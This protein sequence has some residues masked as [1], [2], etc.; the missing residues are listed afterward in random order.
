MLE[1]DVASHLRKTQQRLNYMLREKVGE[2]KL[3]FRLLHILMRIERNPEA[4]QNEIA[5]ELKFTKGS[6]SGYVSRLMELGMLEKSASTKDQRCN[7]LV[8][9]IYGKSIL[10]DYE[11][12]VHL[13]YKDIFI[14]FSPEELASFDASLTKINR[15]LEK[16][17]LEEGKS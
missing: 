8:L 5:K 4:N 1:A 7:R 16:L 17:E 9:T 14:G 12:E 11:E 6:M 2:Y 13:R 10:E 15:N 3:T